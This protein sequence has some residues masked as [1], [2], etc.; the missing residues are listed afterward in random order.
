MP[1]WLTNMEPHW[2]WLSLGVLLAAAE[3]VMPGFFLIWI[4]AAAVVTGVI[5]WIVPLSIPFQ[6]GIFAVLSFV[7]LYSGRRWLKTNPIT[8]TDPN[9]NQRGHRLVGE[10]LTVTKAIEDG[11]GRAKVGDGEWPVRGPDV[12]E[13]AKV[14]VVSADGGLLVVEAV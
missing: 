1:D 8:T 2:A 3:I 11:R 13:G 5:A 12:A 10:V 7:A 6:L 9:L 4:G 14:R